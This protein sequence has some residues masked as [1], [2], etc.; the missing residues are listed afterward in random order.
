MGEVYKAH[1]T[2][3]RRFVAIKVLRSAALVDPERRLRFVQEAQ[4]ASA[5]NHPNIV[6]VHDIGEQDG[7]DYIAMEYVA[8]KTLDALIPRKGM[9]LNEALRIAIQI[10]S[11]LERA[12]AAG[13][14]HRDLKPGNV[15]VGDDGQVKVLDFG[16]P[17]SPNIRTAWRTARPRPRGPTRRKAPFSAP[18]L[19]CLRNRRKAAP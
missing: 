16:L 1:D 15:I 5:L 3:L 6:T 2:R 8:G 12:H 17:S 7:V 4:A 10:A 18:W 13:I 11:G 14:V 9:R 19:I